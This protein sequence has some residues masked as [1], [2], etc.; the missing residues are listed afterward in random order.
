MF[1]DLS[2]FNILFKLYLN[3]NIRFVEFRFCIRTTMILGWPLLTS[4][5]VNFMTKKTNA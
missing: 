3:D 1:G 4:N 5:P 2:F